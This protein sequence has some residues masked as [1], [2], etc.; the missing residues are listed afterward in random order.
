MSMLKGTSRQR[1]GKGAIRKRL[2]LKNRRGIKPNQQS[3][4]YT[5]KTYS[6]PNEQLSS[7]QVVTRLPK[8]NLKY[9]NKH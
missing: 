3:G 7:K 4:T 1:S 8:L 5:I 9:E 2:P 6:K